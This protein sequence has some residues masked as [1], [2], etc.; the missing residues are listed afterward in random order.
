[1]MTPHQRLQGISD[2]AFLLGVMSHLFQRTLVDLE[3]HRL[4]ELIEHAITE[5]ALRDDLI[6]LI[7]LRSSA[8]EVSG[9]SPIVASFEASALVDVDVAVQGRTLQR[10]QSSSAPLPEGSMTIQVPWNLLER[11]PESLGQ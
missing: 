5:V 4:E 1:M 8:C 9:P 10:N 2:P 3:K 6:H 7:F 11:S